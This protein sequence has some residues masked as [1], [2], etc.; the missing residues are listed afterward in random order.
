MQ[1]DTQPV[2][3]RPLSETVVPD[4]ID[5]RLMAKWC[6]NY[7][8]RSVTVGRNYE[9]S[10][11]NLPLNHPP[12]SMNGDSIAG[13]DTECRNDLAFVLMRQMSGITDGQD[14]QNGVRNR[15]LAY[16][17]PCGLFV[18]PNGDTDVIW[19][20]AWM[21]SSLIESYATVGDQASLAGAK[22]ALDALRLY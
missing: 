4:D 18:P 11:W 17:S 13:G 2:D 1:A 7:L 9:S 14:V 6:I 16:Q 19:A 22:N 12:M 21:A 10:Y 5:L 15:I 20:T 3:I 8:T